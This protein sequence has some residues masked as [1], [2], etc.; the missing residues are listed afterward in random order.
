MIFIYSISSTVTNAVAVAGISVQPYRSFPSLSLARSLNISLSLEFLSA[1][2][3][4]R[5]LKYEYTY[6]YYRV[7]VDKRIV[8]VRSI[9][10]RTATLSGR[11]QFYNTGSGAETCLVRF[12]NCTRAC[13]LLFSFLMNIPLRHRRNKVDAMGDLIVKILLYEAHIYNQ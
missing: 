4:V 7:L 11:H 5:G 1:T 10:R 12:G 2:H 13:R 8:N 3:R 9:Y 6:V